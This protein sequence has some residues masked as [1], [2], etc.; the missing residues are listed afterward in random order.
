M[1][2]LGAPLPD[3]VRLDVNMPAM[4]GFEVLGAMKADPQLALIPVV[5]L[6]TSNS[7]DNIRQAYTLHASWY[8]LKSV[9]FAQFLEQGESFVEFW[10]SR[11]LVHWPE[12]CA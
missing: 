2:R 12:Q 4:N 10:T 5:M 11:R 8:L 3:V 9:N 7:Q 6:T 1:R